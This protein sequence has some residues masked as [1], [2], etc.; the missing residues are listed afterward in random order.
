MVN[1]KII[2]QKRLEHLVKEIYNFV[3]RLS[4]PI[5]NDFFSFRKIPNNFR[6][7]QSLHPD[8]NK[9]VKFGFKT[10]T[11]RGQKICAVTPENIRNE[12]F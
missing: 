2:H 6:G 3:N 8:N 5:M 7:F 9:A 12:D 11:Y 4:P 10:I 1:E